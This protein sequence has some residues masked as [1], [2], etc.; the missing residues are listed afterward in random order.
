MK[1]YYRTRARFDANGIKFTVIAY[2]A[3]NGTFDG[4]DVIRYNKATK[5]RE[6]VFSSISLNTA[7]AEFERL[8]HEALHEHDE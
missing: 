1:K 8:T 5:K 4:A 3:Y 7:L 6:R 2:Y